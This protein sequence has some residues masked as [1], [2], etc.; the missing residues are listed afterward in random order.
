M[1]EGE[2]KEG[3]IEKCRERERKGGRKDLVAA[4]KGVGG[5]RKKKGSQVWRFYFTLHTF[6]VKFSDFVIFEKV[7]FA[8][9]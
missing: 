1:K 5:G 4:A 6:Y 9:D 3:E 8:K 7:L 2:R